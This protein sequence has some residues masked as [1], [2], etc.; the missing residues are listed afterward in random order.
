MKRQFYVRVLMNT[1]ARTHRNEY[2]YLLK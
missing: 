2:T 1:S